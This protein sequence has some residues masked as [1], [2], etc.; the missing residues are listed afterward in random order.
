[1]TATLFPHVMIDLETMGTSSDAAIVQIGAVA[2]SLDAI[3]PVFHAHI[4]L[5]S[6]VDAG[7]RIDPD[8]VMWWLGQSDEARRGLIDGKAQMLT[9]AL[10]DFSSWMAAHAAERCGVWG[11]GSDF[12]NVILSGA[13]RRL[14]LPL[15]WRYSG[16]RCFRSLRAICGDSGPLPR[17]GVHHDALDDALTQAIRA[18]ELLLRL[19]VDAA[20][21]G[22]TVATA[23][24][25]Q[26][27]TAA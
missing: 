2:F 24:G 11:N 12:D 7:G 25:N 18:R 26:V 16:N 14:G 10:A 3:G 23:A 22:S 15:P 17:Q 20:P 6:A 4:N 1:M 19:V 13:Y 9:Q 5:K 21:A 8:T 27:A